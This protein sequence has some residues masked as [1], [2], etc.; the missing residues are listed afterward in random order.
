MLTQPL[1]LYVAQVAS[2]VTKIT[3]YRRVVA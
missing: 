1:H 2:A 3:A